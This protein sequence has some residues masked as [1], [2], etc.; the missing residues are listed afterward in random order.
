MKKYWD[1]HVPRRGL[2]GVKKRRGK[3]KEGKGG[4]GHVQTARYGL[5]RLVSAARGDRR[6]RRKFDLTE[7]KGNAK[8]CRKAKGKLGLR[9]H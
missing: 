3:V 8:I 1:N 9:S 5:I 4:K 7:R 6:I 2:V